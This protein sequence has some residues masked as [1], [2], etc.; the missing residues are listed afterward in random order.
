VP[1]TV[2][3]RLR[4]EAHFRAILCLV[5][6]SGASA[7]ALV[8]AAFVI[9]F[10]WPQEAVAT[11]RE[12]VAAGNI[13]DFEIGRPQQFLEG[14]FWLVRVSQTEVIALYQRDPKL[15]CTV[16][17]RENFRFIDPRTGQ[18]REGW[19]RNPCHGQ[20]YDLDGH[21]VYGPCIRGLDRRPVTL[22]NDGSVVVNI[23]DRRLIPGQSLRP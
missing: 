10:V 11:P 18:S 2:A 3:W 16:P 1:A 5:L 4:S 21:C 12:H 17:W 8:V 13:S 15:G 14:K 19:F 6:L 9:S 22:S 23:S 20:T 7:V